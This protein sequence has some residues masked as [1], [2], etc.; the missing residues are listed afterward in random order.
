PAQPKPIVLVGFMAAGKSLIGGL[1]AERLGIPFVDT[2]KVIE[3]EFG[4]SIAGIFRDRGEQVFRDAER[5]LIRRLLDGSERVIAAGGGAFIDPD[6]RGSLN[7]HAQTVWLDPPFEVI[8]VRIAGS[9][10]RPLVSGR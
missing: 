1:L 3:D 2:D 4:T 9:D 8:M 10:V 6:T 7:R 5:S